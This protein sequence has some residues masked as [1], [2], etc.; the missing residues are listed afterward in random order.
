MRF[1]SIQRFCL[2]RKRFGII[3]VLFL[4]YSS[5]SPLSNLLSSLSLVHSPSP[6]NLAALSEPTSLQLSRSTATRL[7]PL[8]MTRV[9]KTSADG[10]ITSVVWPSLANANIF[11]FFNV[12]IKVADEE[13]EEIIFNRVRR[14][15][16]RAGIL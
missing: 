8:V 1:Y 10:D 14:S 13:P 3:P 15:V 9:P 2:I 7:A 12:Q 5:R 11:N 16:L 6:P 4:A